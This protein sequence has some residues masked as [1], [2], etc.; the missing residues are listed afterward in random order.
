MP[1][2]NKCKCHVASTR[3]QR[4]HVMQQ[5]PLVMHLFFTGLREQILFQ[6]FGLIVNFSPFL[7]HILSS[8][9]DTTWHPPGYHTY[10]L[11]FTAPFAPYY[12]DQATQRM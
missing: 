3:G 7:C 6:I 8:T 11:K 9:P 1:T 5:T 2:Q 4:R 12:C 10:H